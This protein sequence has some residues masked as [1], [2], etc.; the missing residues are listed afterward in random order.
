[1]ND[2]SSQVTKN[3]DSTSKNETN[4]GNKNDSA[5]SVG[6]EAIFGTQDTTLNEKQSPTKIMVDAETAAQ[7]I[8]FETSAN[9]IDTDF[10]VPKWPKYDEPSLEK[11]QIQKELL[12]VNGQA[13]K[14]KN[15]FDQI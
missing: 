2:S 14:W 6:Y 8:N 7:K 9:L 11:P 12:E 15:L 4:Q 1:M 10:S 13:I 5:K 3:D